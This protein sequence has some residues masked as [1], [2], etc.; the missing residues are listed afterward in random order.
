M[1]MHKTCDGAKRRDFLKVGALGFAGLS[2][3]QYL[4]IAQ[5]GGVKSTAKAKSAIFINLPGGPSHM[6]TFDMKPDAPAEYRGEFNP[7]DTNVPGIQICEHL[8]ELAKV[9]DKFVILKG[10][11]HTLAAHQLGSEY[12]NTG[13]RPL[14]SLEFPGYGAVISKERPTVPELPPFV[15]I[16][17][18]SQRPGYLGVQ[19]A[20][21]HTG[22]TPR[23]GQSYSVRG[24]DLRNGLTVSD[25]ERRKNLR[26]DLDTAFSGFE[27]QNDLLKGLDRFSQQAYDM[28]TSPQARNAFDVSKESPEFSQMFGESPFGQSCL[29]ATRLIDSGV[30]FVSVSTGGWDTHRDGWNNLKTRLLPPLDQ[31]LA[32]LFKGLEMKG[33]LEET[34]VL[35]TGEFGRTPKINNERVGRDHYPRAMFMLMAGGGISGGRVIGASDDKALGPLNEAIT[36]DDVAASYYHALGIN[37]EQEY[38]TSTGRPVMI[39]RDGHVINELFT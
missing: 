20:P 7:I 2:L 6:D 3:S 25:I 17:N 18:T 30:R 36:P 38:H 29:L 14:P 15:S 26:G 1:A 4:N 37:H 11:S 19:Y 39:V 34:A 28:V 27:Q 8:P 22:S 12:V 24:L 33:L 13:N 31:G 35:V 32:A 5:A 21:L 23:A 16:P 10:V 9:M